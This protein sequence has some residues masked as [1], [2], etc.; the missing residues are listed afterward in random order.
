MTIPMTGPNSNGAEANAHRVIDRYG[1]SVEHLGNDWC[2]VTYN[3]L[4]AEEFIR[5]ANANTVNGWGALAIGRVNPTKPSVP[6]HK[7]PWHTGFTGRDGR[8]AHLSEVERWP[9][10]VARR[11]AFGHE[12]GVLNLGARVPVG[13]VGLDIDEY[14]D[15]HGLRTLREHERRFGPLP[16]TH[17]VTA[18]PF[19]TGSGIRLYAVPDDWAGVGELSGGCVE[20]IQRHHRFIAAPGSVHH[21]GTPY[22]LYGPTG[23]ETPSGV[24]PAR[25][26][27]PSLPERW[28]HALYRRARLRG[29]PTNADEVAAFA[30]DYT[31][32]QFPHMLAATVLAVREATGDGETR[33]AYHRALFIAARKARAG[34]YPWTRAVLEIQVAAEH[35]YAERGR[36]LDPYDFARSVEHAVTQALD[37]TPG[38]IAEWGS[39][40]T[41][42]TPIP[43]MGRRPSPPRFAPSAPTLRPRVQRTAP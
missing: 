33:N 30:A 26:E 8:D 23:A 16:P 43:L 37:M 42:T 12:R 35:A 20:L 5:C 14:G 4:D 13:V 36:E 25:S 15:K 10:N 7:T 27:L 38:E 3:G 2:S 19:D 24:L 1:A 32:D 21:T 18:R 34:C 31:F 11:I 40:R 41:P 17:V 22:R 28:L 29:A 6:P 39:E 9:K